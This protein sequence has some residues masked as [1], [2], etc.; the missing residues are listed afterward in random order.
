MDLGVCIIF[1]VLRLI[2]LLLVLRQRKYALELLARA[3]MLKC[4]RVTTPMSSSE[5]LC[6]ADGDVLLSEDATHYRSLVGGV[7]YSA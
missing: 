2:H 1:W 4:S 6:S 7:Q 3:G 5:G